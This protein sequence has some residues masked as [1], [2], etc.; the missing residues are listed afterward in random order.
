MV[1]FLSVHAKTK[2]H[3]RRARVSHPSP[4]ETRIILG[5][6]AG[7]IVLKSLRDPPTGL[8]VPQRLYV[9]SQVPQSRTNMQHVRNCASLPD[10]ENAED[11]GKGQRECWE[12]WEC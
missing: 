9:S 3:A 1:S 4:R 12:C 7:V 5:R 10:V 11:V 6:R 8:V 2:R